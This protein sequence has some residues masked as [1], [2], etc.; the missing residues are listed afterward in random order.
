MDENIEGLDSENQDGQTGDQDS[1]QNSEVLA[2]KNKELFARVK[3]SEEEKRALKAKLQEL[4]QKVPEKKEESVKPV[5]SDLSMSDFLEMRK[6]KLSD[7]EIA[8][9]VAE[10]KV[11]GTTPAKLMTSE[12]F[13]LGLEAKRK[14]KEVEQTTLPPSSRAAIVEN[15]SWDELTPEERKKPENIVK[16]FKAKTGGGKTE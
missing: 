9:V 6:Q 12:G 7:E 11:L 2:Q 1:Q 5:E 3:K 10:A 16:A 4:E 13:K 14:K 15:K 8:D